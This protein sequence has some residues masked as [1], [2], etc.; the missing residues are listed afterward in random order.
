MIRKAL[1]EVNGSVTHAA[2]LLGM[3]YQGLAY[4]I[5]SRHPDLLKERTPVRRR[6]YRKDHVQ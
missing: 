3:S 6:R 1:V 5:E 4:L 2:S